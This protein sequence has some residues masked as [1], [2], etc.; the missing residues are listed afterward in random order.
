M[1][2]IVMLLVILSMGF[3][4]CSGILKF[5]REGS[6]PADIVI[7]N[8]RIWTSDSL[9]PRAQ[10]VAITGEIISYVGSN[11]GAMDFIGEDTQVI[12]A[13]KRRITP[14]FVDNHCHVLWIGGLLA[15]MPVDLYECNS[16]EDVAEV[17]RKTAEDK[18]DLPFVG[19][20]GW[21]P[22]YLP[23]R[24]PTK[25]MLD[26]I[27]SDRPVI[28]M[29]YSGQGGW[30]N[31]QAIDI[32]SKADPNAFSYLAPVKDET[33]GDWTGEFKHFHAFNFLNFFTWDDLG[34]DG[35]RMFEDKIKEALHSGISTGVTAYHDVQIYD[36]FIPF[37]LDMN[38]KGEFNDVRV[39]L[40]YYIGHEELHN[41]EK[42]ISNLKY[43]KGLD[44]KYSDD[45]F[46][47]GNSAKMYIDGTADNLTC[48]MLEPFSSD[49]GNYGEPVWTQ[50]EFDTLV[51]I[52]DILKIQACTHSVGD[53]GIHRVINSYEKA[54]KKN[55]SIDARHRSEHCELPIPEDIE[56]MAELGIY[57]SMQPCHFY[58]CDEPIALALGE[59]RVKGI[60]PWNSLSEA[61]VS[62]SFG[63]DWCTSPFN[64][65]Y[66][67]L[68]ASKRMNYKNEMNWKKEEK[69]PIG[70]AINFWTIGSAKALFWDDKI[71]SIEVGKYADLV[72]F[73]TD[74]MEVGTL[75][76][77]LTHEID[78]GTLDDFVDITMVGGKIVYKK[79]GAEL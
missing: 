72:I 55:S 48:F 18:P 52:L 78:L 35:R 66:G 16:L 51:N 62:V 19:G 9:Q 57:A 24:T 73:N 45:H 43:W 30:M 68:I 40:A 63:S 49:P 2:K 71:G 22:E 27:V 41:E 21:K 10:A 70:D 36:E 29:S 58:G 37:L 65:F 69:V 59:D 38:K 17:V 54:I 50:D 6:N 11:E 34:E 25:E 56:R 60:M 76:F 46:N 26:E 39:R 47:I 23:N 32:C 8:A 64:P 67:L 53:A 79:E 28:L 74:P 14:G 12:Q 13:R 4:S 7:L 3:I 75:W 1:K 44:E 33:T 61:G 15:L 20:I 77:L 31:S 42:L 5:T